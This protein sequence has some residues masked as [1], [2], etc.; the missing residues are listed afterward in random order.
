MISLF[1]TID[2]ISVLS[3]GSS[4]ASVGSSFQASSAVITGGFG[5]VV[6][7]R[8]FVAV[9]VA[10]VVVYPPR[11]SDATITEYTYD[12]SVDNRHGGVEAEIYASGMRPLVGVIVDPARRTQGTKMKSMLGIGT[13]F[14]LSAS[15]Q[16]DEASRGGFTAEH[17]A[18]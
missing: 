10:D 6:S 16:S 5:S 3:S 18:H 12:D 7:D 8:G 14:S 13:S 11:F 15:R 9:I 17:E 4:V 2:L 1:P